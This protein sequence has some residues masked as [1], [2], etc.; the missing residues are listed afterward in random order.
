MNPGIRKLKS[1]SLRVASPTG[2]PSE[3]Q[4]HVRELIDVQSNNPRKGHATALLNNVCKE[5]DRDWLTLMVQVKPFDDGMGMDK[6][7]R[8]YGRFGFVEIQQEPAVLMARSP[9]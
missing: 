1:A 7:R 6:L 5:A 8:W 4:D 9:R 3:M 2:L